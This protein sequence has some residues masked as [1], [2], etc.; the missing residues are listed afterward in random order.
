[1]SA[2][3]HNGPGHGKI[4]GGTESDAVH[5]SLLARSGRTPAC[6]IRAAAERMY[7]HSSMRGSSSVHGEMSEE[8]QQKSCD[9]VGGINNGDA[10]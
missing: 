9:I 3:F 7:R 1:M 2:D 5:S 4:T 10:Q 6:H 8:K